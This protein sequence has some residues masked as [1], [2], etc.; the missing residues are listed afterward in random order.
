[1]NGVLFLP[2]VLEDPSLWCSQR[3]VHWLPAHVVQLYKQHRYV[4]LWDFI[5]SVS[6][7]LLTLNKDACAG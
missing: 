4:T 5:S 7:L 1:M 2:T 3:A 6:L